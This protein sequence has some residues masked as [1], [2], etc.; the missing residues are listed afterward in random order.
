MPLQSPINPRKLKDD[1]YYESKSIE[2]LINQVE[3]VSNNKAQPKTDLEK[4]M[5][6]ETSKILTSL[7]IL[8][9]LTRPGLYEKTQKD[10]KSIADYIYQFNQRMQT[11]QN[12]L[13]SLQTQL[14]AS[15]D[16]AKKNELNNLI[17]FGNTIS[18]F[19]ETSYN[20]RTET[21]I[22]NK[23]LTK[24]ILDN[25]TSHTYAATKHA[26]LADVAIHNTS[27][28]PLIKFTKKMGS[29]GFGVVY[30]ATILDE[31]LR[32][33]LIEKH[34]L[35]ENERDV[36]IKQLIDVQGMA[37]TEED[38]R[39]FVD[40]GIIGSELT[41]KLSGNV[42]DIPCSLSTYALIDNKPVIICRKEENGNVLDYF[43]KLLMNE[44]KASPFS[45]MNNA[46][47]DFYRSK[48]INK[49][50]K[51]FP[52]DNEVSREVKKCLDVLL[53]FREETDPDKFKKMT[54]TKRGEILSAGL[55]EIEAARIKLSEFSATQ[56]SEDL[57]HFLKEADNYIHRSVMQRMDTFVANKIMTPK[58]Q[59]AFKD[60][61]L[62]NPQSVPSSSGKKF[63]HSDRRVL[64]SRIFNDTL[65]NLNF[66]DDN[67]VI[68]SD[69]AARNI[70]LGKHHAHIIDF[71]RA[72]KSDTFS[73][74]TNPNHRP[75]KWH[76]QSS[77]LSDN[78]TSYNDL[79]AYKISLLE[80][81]AQAAGLNHMQIFG[82][83][84]NA[85][86]YYYSTENGD[87]ATLEKLSSEL[88][89]HL[90]ANIHQL[91]CQE[92]REIYKQINPKPLLNLN[93]G[94][95]QPYAIFR[96]DPPAVH[97]ELLELINKK[98]ENIK[99]QDYLKKHGAL[100]P[101]QEQKMQSLLTEMDK[102]DQKENEL[103]TTLRAE[104]KNERKKMIVL[105]EKLEN[106]YA[107]KETLKAEKNKEAK[108]EINKE[109]KA[110]KKQKQSA[111]LLFFKSLDKTTTEK[112][113]APKESPYQ[114]I[115]VT[116][117]KK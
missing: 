86:F 70:C 85:D 12:T 115:D 31:N 2:N 16:D 24:E 20:K 116:R 41:N 18:Q 39:S 90:D 40:E 75:V 52:D 80:M 76:S 65:K 78:L 101:A 103:Y 91:R 97:N 35:E 36:V 79:I 43:Q 113:N 23:L 92:V 94:E 50:I 111:S 14:D 7:H 55:K 11:Y 34:I 8:R 71:G 57:Q 47:K 108:V 9:Q 3:Q 87:K 5:L 89:K 81:L 10:M 46:D 32:K 68:H 56:S 19:C 96:A 4:L 64:L 88:E 29:G 100:S 73:S 37:V 15:E 66:L 30:L 98:N 53:K 22:R 95:S 69:I 102:L 60:T 28:H 59:S 107:P 54:P 48:Q 38:Y 26:R 42:T 58:Q 82:K 6:D 62:P 114:A 13:A 109:P 33:Q 110:E 74:E 84:S 45:N 25:T 61:Y 51:S 17:G 93:P 77:L 44:Y 99:E 27:T 63:P 112:R 67:N 105:F 72:S 104:T 1:S 83:M 21:L 117:H 49:F 106:Q